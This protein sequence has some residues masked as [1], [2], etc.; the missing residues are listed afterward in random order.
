[1][2]YVDNRIFIFLGHRCLLQSLQDNLRLV[3]FRILVYRKPKRTLLFSHSLCLPLS[4]ICHCLS[5][6]LTHPF[7]LQH[8][9]QH[10][11]F[12]TI[13]YLLVHLLCTKCPTFPPLYS[14]L[15]YLLISSLF[16]SLSVPLTA[17]SHKSLTTTFPH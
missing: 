16:Y 5:T 9:R 17:H 10:L 3:H 2:I 12:L 11:V 6:P 8:I 15:L 7:S 4:F 1:M 13:A 14:L